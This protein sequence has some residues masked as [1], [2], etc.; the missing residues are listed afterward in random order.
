MPPLERAGIEVHCLGGTGK[1]HFLPVVRRLTRLLS[2]RRPQLVQSFLFHANLAGRIAAR[3]AGV[4]CVLS[5]IRVA[6]RQQ[7]W[8]LWLDRLTSR[9][10]NRYVCVSQSVAQ[11]S[12]AEG[13][14]PAEKMVVIPNGIDLEHYPAEPADLSRFGVAPGRRVITYVG[15]LEPQKG[16]HWL[17]EMAPLWFARLPDCDLLLV[18][19]G[20]DQPQLE[21]LATASGIGSRV[22]FAG[23]QADV[24]RI[25][26][27]SELLVLPS[28][29]E[30]MPNVVLQA[31]ASRLPVVSTDVEGVRELL[32]PQ[33]DSQTVAYGDSSGLSSRISQILSDVEQSKR[34]GELNRKRVAEEFSLQRMV[35]AYEDL[36]ES[37]IGSKK[38]V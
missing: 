3:Q 30:G 13:G 20:P 25:L 7:R 24:P 17:L 6:E 18:G 28:Q 10:V 16:V 8:H 36:W 37:L 22:H 32:G 27:A 5:G 31:M 29:W 33:A 11:F 19:K 21:Q 34:L 9:R 23:W 26:A 12:V 35:A 2:E 14:L 15:R 4:E 38:T 1:R